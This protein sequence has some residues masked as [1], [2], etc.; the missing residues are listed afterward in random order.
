MNKM[1][2]KLRNFSLVILLLIILLSLN[3]ISAADLCW[4]QGG[5]SPSSAVA[6]CNNAQI[7]GV[8]GSAIMYLSASTNAHGA[9]INNPDYSSVLC[10]AVASGSS[11]CT[12]NNKVVGLSAITNAHAERPDEPTPN[13][14]TYNVCYQ[15]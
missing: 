11:S 14:N 7:G 15:N 13:Y 2:K 12:G 1:L 8:N 6:N 3:Q 10:C 4:I 5:T 9:L